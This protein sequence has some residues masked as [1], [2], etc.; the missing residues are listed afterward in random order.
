MGRLDPATGKIDEFPI[1][2]KN[3]VARKGGMDSEGNVWVGLHGAG[4]LMKD[5]LQDRQNDHLRSAHRGCRTVLR[6][7]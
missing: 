2:V 6:S 3:P 1:F 4:K 7:G 5:R